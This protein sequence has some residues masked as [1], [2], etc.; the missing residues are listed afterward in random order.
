MDYRLTK[1]YEQL[2]QK[3]HNDP[4]PKSLTSAYQEIMLH[5]R[6]L[7]GN[8]QLR[9]EIQ[10]ADSNLKT[11]PAGPQGIR[12][13]PTGT[14]SHEDLIKLFNKLKLQLIKKINPK[15]QGAYSGQL[16][17]Y[18][19]KNSA[20]Q[21][22]YFIVLGKGIGFSKRDEL[23]AVDN[24]AQQIQ[25]AITK[26][27]QEYIKLSIN[28]DI[29]KVDGIRS[30]PGNPKSDFEF[31][32][33]H[34]PVFW[35]SHKDGTK[36]KDHQQYGGLTCVSGKSVC[37]HPET[38]SFVNEISKRYSKG[39]PPGASVWRKIKDPQLKLFSIFGFDYGTKFGP[40][41]V[42][43]L[44]QGTVTL[45]PKGNNV[46]EINSAHSVF[47]GQLPTETYE[48]ILYGRFSGSRGGNHGI[49]DLRTGILPLAKVSTKAL[50]I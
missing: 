46:Y 20:T 28:G 45:V 11:N 32:F 42:N 13:Q 48:P 44:Y 1:I 22:D 5:E 25:N 2:L 49:K 41:N 47:N 35:I 33:Q 15:E 43:A 4:A 6:S 12:I 38:I 36:A 23:A 37:G 27:Q 24:I 50:N 14:F 29:K 21:E 10:S 9:F 8:A 39:M 18:H 26:E 31:I 16:P 30:T 7:S 40:N 17:T 3:T 19:V 34:N